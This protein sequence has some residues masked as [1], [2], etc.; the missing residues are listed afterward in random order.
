MGNRATTTYIEK[1]KKWWAMGNKNEWKKNI[2]VVVVV[3]SYCR[4]LGGYLSLRLAGQPFD[5]LS[6]PEVKAPFSASKAKWNTRNEPN[7][8]GNGRGS[9]DDGRQTGWIKRI[10]WWSQTSLFLTDS[11]STV[12]DIIK[13]VWVSAAE[14]L[15][16]SQQYGM[17]LV[18]LAANKNLR[19]INSVYS[20]VKRGKSKSKLIEWEHGC[21]IK[22]EQS[23][24]DL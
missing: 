1:K 14:K 6:T 5:D 8:T 13:C 11:K 7:R 15:R 9:F 19:Y 22:L 12:T 20:K 2:V 23:N 4:L 21:L 3:V 16:A 17:V 18:A 10:E 24:W